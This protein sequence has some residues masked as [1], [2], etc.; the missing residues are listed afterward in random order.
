MLFMPIFVTL[1]VINKYKLQ[2][3]YRHDKFRAKIV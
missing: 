3:I 1:I 2:Q